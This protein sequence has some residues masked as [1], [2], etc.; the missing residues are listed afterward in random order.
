MNITEARSACGD[1]IKD[2]T[3]KTDTKEVRKIYT[4]PQYHGGYDGPLYV[5]DGVWKEVS[6]PS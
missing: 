2:G 6:P 4:N 5:A 3:K 1:G